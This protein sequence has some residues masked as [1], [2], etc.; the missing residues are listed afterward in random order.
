MN[1]LH[2]L[3][4]FGFLSVLLGWSAYAWRIILSLLIVF[5]ISLVYTSKAD[6]N[7]SFSP[8]VDKDGQITRPTDF[9]EKWTYLGSWVHPNSEKD[10][11]HNVYTQPGVV[12]KYKENGSKFPDGAVLVK[13]V[14]STKSQNMTTGKD[15]IH[16]QDLV[17]WF[18][19]I[20]DEKGRFPDNPKWGDGWGWALYY[21][22]DPS[23]DVSTNYKVDCLGCHIPAKQTDWIYIQGYPVLK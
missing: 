10:G 12:E 22:D 16:A 19:M 5:S 17:L 1:K 6:E 20:K 7:G 9:K 14:R 23:K 21:A 3:F 13:E 15:V 4:S 8:Y 2:L 11:M 18:V